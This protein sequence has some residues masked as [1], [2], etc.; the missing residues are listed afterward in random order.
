L[1]AEGV[2]RRKILVRASR[3]SGQ[4]GVRKEAIASGVED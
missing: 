1:S 4:S 2:Q 3:R